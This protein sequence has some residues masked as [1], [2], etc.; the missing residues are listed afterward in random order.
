MVGADPMARQAEVEREA[1]SFAG[2]R[3][4]GTAANL[5]PRVTGGSQGAGRSTA[6]RAPGTTG[7]ARS[8]AA[9]GLRKPSDAE[10]GPHNFGGGEG[11][12][13]GRGA[14]MRPPAGR[15]RK[16]NLDE[17]GPGREEAPAGADGFVRPEKPD[18]AVS[19]W[20]KGG[21]GRP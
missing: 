7:V 12:P 1:G 4:Y 14:G 8:A 5:P 16:P 3:T 19:N 17:M 15:A 11:M 20:R 13:S 6:G 10:M 2:E 18:P 9:G 21:R